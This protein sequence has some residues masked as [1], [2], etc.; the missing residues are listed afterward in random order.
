M[1]PSPDNTE[2]TP[3]ASTPPTVVAELTPADLDDLFR[4]LAA[5][6]QLQH[7]AVKLAPGHTD[8]APASLDLVNA[9]LV[10]NQPETHAVQIRYTYND[11]LWIDT[12][13]R[14]G[15]AFRLLRV[16]HA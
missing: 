14:D 1:P 4:D 12:L 10:L 13:T 8:A 3:D 16:Q 6:A 11:N 9:R 15:Q 7:I 2:P 5:C